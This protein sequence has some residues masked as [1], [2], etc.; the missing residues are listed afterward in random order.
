MLI[1]A[2]SCQ[3][4]PYTLKSQSRFRWLGA[5]SRLH[6][7]ARTC[8]AGQQ[9]G[10]STALTP[11]PFVVYLY[12]ALWKQLASGCHLASYLSP[13]CKLSPGSPAAPLPPLGRLLPS[14]FLVFKKQKKNH[15]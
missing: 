1:N 13:L 8:W 15:L 4:Y 9:E 7:P 5:A 2:F 10:A 6:F 12:P 3:C 14:H 11:N